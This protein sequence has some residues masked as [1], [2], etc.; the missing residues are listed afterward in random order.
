MATKT[1]ATKPKH[2]RGTGRV[3]NAEK[4]DNAFGLKEPRS[5][6]PTDLKFGQGL[7]RH[8]K[9]GVNLEKLVKIWKEEPAVMV[10]PTME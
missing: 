8:P 7:L 4:A 3:P 5:W 6:D 2:L 10:L 9:D 1:S